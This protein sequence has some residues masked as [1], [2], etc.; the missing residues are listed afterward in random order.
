M[1]E[2]TPEKDYTFCLM[3]GIKMRHIGGPYNVETRKPSYEL[4]VSVPSHVRDQVEVN[5]VLLGTP[6]NCK[7]A[8]DLKNKSRWPAFVTIKKDGQMIKSITG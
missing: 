3:P 6:E 5:Q 1:T 7:W 2:S 8:W 4:H